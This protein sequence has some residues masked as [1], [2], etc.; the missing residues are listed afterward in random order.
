MKAKGTKARRRKIR[1][2]KV[3]ERSGRAMKTQATVSKG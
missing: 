1:S 3:S 2:P